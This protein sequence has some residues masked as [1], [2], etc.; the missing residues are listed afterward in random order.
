ME[1]QDMSAGGHL[2]GPDAEMRID[3]IDTENM[4]I[5]SGHDRK[6]PALTR[7]RILRPDNRCDV[8]LGPA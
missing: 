3:S 1:L 8:S 6:G 5:G 7:S 2:D 4:R